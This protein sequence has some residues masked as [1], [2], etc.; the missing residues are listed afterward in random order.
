[1]KHSIVMGIDTFGNSFCD[2]LTNS[3]EIM[4]LLNLLYSS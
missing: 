1:M 2:L 3:L 4:K